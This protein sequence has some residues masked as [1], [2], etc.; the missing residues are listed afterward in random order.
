MVHTETLIRSASLRPILLRQVNIARHLEASLAH[1]T[2]SDDDQVGITTKVDALDLEDR[3]VDRER[4]FVLKRA[5][6]SLARTHV[7]CL[8]KYDQPWNPRNI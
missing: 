5:G 8:D 3:P 1:R 2:A 4:I 6:Y 7:G